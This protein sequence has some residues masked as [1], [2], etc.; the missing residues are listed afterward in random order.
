MGVQK[1]LKILSAQARQKSHLT[2]WISIIYLNLLRGNQRKKENLLD[3]K[4]TLKRY[5][6]GLNKFR[7][8]NYY[9]PRTGH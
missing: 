6:P 8:N 3:P 5:W 4:G 7:P 9:S 2:R 1:R